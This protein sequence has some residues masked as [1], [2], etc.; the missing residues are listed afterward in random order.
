M[1]EGIW[2]T[3]ETQGI[4]PPPYLRNLLEIF[5]PNILIIGYKLMIIIW[6]SLVISQRYT[7]MEAA[8]QETV[9]ILRQLEWNGR[10]NIVGFWL[11]Q[12]LLVDLWWRFPWSNGNSNTTVKN[13]YGHWIWNICKTSRLVGGTLQELK[14]WNYW[15]YVY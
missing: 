3:T 15:Y 6:N 12:W 10:N 13:F 2:P 7:K 9:D 5:I 4:L 14:K 1:L 8:R 11:L